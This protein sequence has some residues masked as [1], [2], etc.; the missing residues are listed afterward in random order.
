MEIWCHHID[1][2][3][4]PIG[5]LF[6]V[7]LENDTQ[8]IGHL[9]EKVKETNQ[10]P[11]KDVNAFD[12]VVWRCADPG[13]TFDGSNRENFDDQIQKL[14]S[15]QKAQILV[16]RQKI[17]GLNFSDDEILFVQMPGAFLAPSFHAV[18][19]SQ[20]ASICFVPPHGPQE[21]AH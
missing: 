1:H 7:F 14:F 18:R 6:S 2:K 17:A 13:A 4:K 8:N 11:M 16:P 3:K 20:V 19:Y 12:L 21:K 9:R 15:S 10:V 5:N